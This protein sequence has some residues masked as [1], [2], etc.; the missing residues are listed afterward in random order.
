MSSGRAGQATRN[1]RDTIR[2][3]IT[4]SSHPRPICVRAVC[5][6]A[7]LWAARHYA[8]FCRGYRHLNLVPNPVLAALGWYLVRKRPD[9]AVPAY[10]SDG[11]L[12]D[13][14]CGSGASV[15][16]MQYMGLESRGSRSFRIG[17]SRRKMSPALRLQPA[18]LMF[19]NPARKPLI[20]LS[21]RTRW[22]TFP[23]WSD[24]FALSSQP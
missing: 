21:R 3:I 19:W 5:D 9:L 10:I 2:R 12:C 20:G 24:A 18:H 15:A 13:F 14:G 16:V 7:G 22:N 4:R 6:G 11:T 8:R 1:W 17:C 23:M